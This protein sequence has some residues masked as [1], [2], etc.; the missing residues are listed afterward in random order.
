MII[1]LED[2]EMRKEIQIILINSIFWS[3]AGG[4]LGPI[5]AIFV[6]EI[7]GDILITGSAYAAFAFTSGFMML[8]TGKIADSVKKPEYILILGTFLG[9][10]GNAGYLLVSN[11]THLFIV[12]IILGVSG[13][14]SVPVID[15]LFSRYSEQKKTFLEWGTWES[16][17]LIGTA[18]AALIGSFIVQNFGFKELFVSMSICSFL[19]FLG[20]VF[21]SQEINK[22]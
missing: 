10:L 15:G 3:F 1:V 22:K 14:L 20:S 18:I 12:Q 21:L 4:M 17:W 7:G 19:T 9:F 2:S 16:L 13:S 6:R 11:I 8:F 5:Y